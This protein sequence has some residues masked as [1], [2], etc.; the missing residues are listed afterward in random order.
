MKGSQKNDHLYEFNKIICDCSKI[1][2]NLKE[3]HMALMLR[4]LPPWYEHLVIT[5]PDE[6]DKIE[7]EDVTS[8]ILSNKLT[9]KGKHDDD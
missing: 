3:K 7:R 1:N 6:K 5:L 8:L 9:K 4:S 2:A